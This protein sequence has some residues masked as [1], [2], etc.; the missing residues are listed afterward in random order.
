MLN[1]FYILEALRHDDMPRLLLGRAR[2][3]IEQLPTRNVFLEA[4]RL[5][6]IQGFLRLILESTQ[7]EQLQNTRTHYIHKLVYRV[8]RFNK[9]QN[10]RRNWTDCQVKSKVISYMLMKSLTFFSLGAARALQHKDRKQWFL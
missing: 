5:N 7:T 4:L 10:R 6:N 3:D 2:K 1:V 9:S 8:K